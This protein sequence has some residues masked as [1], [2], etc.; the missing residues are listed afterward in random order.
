MYPSCRV[1]ELGLAVPPFDRSDKM[2]LGMLRPPNRKRLLCASTGT[3]RQLGRPNRR[4]IFPF[5][6][7]DGDNRASELP[8]G[9]DLVSFASDN[10]A[11]HGGGHNVT[12]L[13]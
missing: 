8:A 12:I 4:R 10:N 9:K 13:L 6:G 7:A 5:G 1:S 2:M 3:S 11:R